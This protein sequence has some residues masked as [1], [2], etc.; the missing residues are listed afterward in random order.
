MSRASK[1]AMDAIHRALAETFKDILEN[2]EEEVNKETGEVVRVT[3]K[4]STLN[5]IRQF[6]K[7]NGVDSAGGPDSPVDELAQTARQSLPF[8]THTDEHGLAN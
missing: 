8:P 7:D 5:A 1:A 6:L 3:P 2:G 4:A